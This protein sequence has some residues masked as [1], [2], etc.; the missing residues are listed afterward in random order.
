MKKI[1]LFRHGEVE[2]SFRKRFRGTLDCELSPYGQRMSQA[3]ARFLVENRVDK[4][5]TSGKKRA[6]Y[7][8]SLLTAAG[9]PHEIET[10]FREVHFGDWEG[11]S[12]AEVESQ[13]PAEAHRY[14]HQFDEMQFPNGEAIRDVKARVLEAWEELIRQ[15]FESIAIVGHSTTN[16]CLMS[17]LQN[18]KFRDLGLQIIGSMHEFGITNDKVS[19]LR[20]NVVL[21][22]TE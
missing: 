15:P 14:H 8:G 19:I 13:F 17:H 3:N 4:I 16:T 9:I 12:W 6:D 1:F 2:H 11:K 20:E 7:V 5:I 18:K 22:P 10:R 21:Y